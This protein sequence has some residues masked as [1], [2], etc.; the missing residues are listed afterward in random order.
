M[1]ILIIVIVIVLLLLFV[2]YMK[3]NEINSLIDNLKNSLKMYEQST[4]FKKLEEFVKLDS[5]IFRLSENYE[6]VLKF[7]SVGYKIEEITFDK[8]KQESEVYYLFKDKWSVVSKCLFK[9]S[10]DKYYIAEG[11]LKMKNTKYE[12][13][14]PTENLKLLK[15]VK[16]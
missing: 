2:V 14:N 10:E 4:E 6:T 16:N 3:L 1:K 15:I 7:F 11:L 12:I 9:D 8:I 13:V 5:G